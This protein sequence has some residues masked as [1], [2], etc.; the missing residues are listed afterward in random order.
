MGVCRWGALRCFLIWV[1]HF[2]IWQ[3]R[4]GLPLGSAAVVAG[5]LETSAPA[6]PAEVDLICHFLIWQV[7]NM[8]SPAEVDL[9]SAS[10]D[11]LEAAIGGSLLCAEH[12][13]V[14][15]YAVTPGAP[16]Y[17]GAMF[18][19]FRQVVQSRGPEESWLSLLQQTN[20][21]LSSWSHS[22]RAFPS[23]EISSTCRGAPF[24]PADLTS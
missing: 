13:H 2:L 8:A 6:S 21:L 12:D 16:A 22:S 20:E 1:C 4:G 11:D 15:G 3:V 7:P 17:R 18:A 9:S 19:A 14:W 5:V 24:S 10:H 23:M